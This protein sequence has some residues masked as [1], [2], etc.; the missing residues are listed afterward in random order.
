MQIFITQGPGR[1]RANVSSVNATEFCRFLLTIDF[2]SREKRWTLNLKCKTEKHQSYWWIIE[3]AERKNLKALLSER[4]A[5]SVVVTL[6]NVRYDTCP[7]RTAVSSH[8]IVAEW[9]SP[10][11]HG[12][13]EREKIRAS[14]RSNMDHAGIHSH[15]VS[16]SLL[17]R[18]AAEA[19]CWLCLY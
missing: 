17:R 15:S 6:S 7:S 2:N 3:K 19:P 5:G 1:N 12:A 18:E 10:Q 11:R 13:C 14:E 8:I 4:W 9:T 16:P